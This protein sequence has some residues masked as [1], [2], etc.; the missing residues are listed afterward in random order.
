M[1]EVR[2]GPGRPLCSTC[3]TCGALKSDRPAT[4]IAN[5]V[6]ESIREMLKT[7]SSIQL[8]SPSKVEY[9]RAGLTRLRA[10]VRRRGN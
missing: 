8:S 7:A 2:T 6:S 10:L 1:A 9:L 5:I 3:P 4:E